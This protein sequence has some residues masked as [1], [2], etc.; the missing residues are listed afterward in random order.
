MYKVAFQYGGKK[1]VIEIESY[2]SVEVLKNKIKETTKVPLIQQR[3]EI[4]DKEKRIVLEN[5][6]TLNQF[7]NY[8]ENGSL[9]LFFKN[10]G[11]QI[12][13]RTLFFLEYLGPFLLWVFFFLINLSKLNGY[14]VL[15]TALVLLHYGKRLYESIYVHIFSNVSVPY[16][17]A[18]RN[19]VMYWFVFGTLVPIEIYY[20]RSMSL[21]PCLFP[22]RVSELFFTLIFLIS[23]YFNYQCHMVLRN[24]RFETVNG[25]VVETKKRLIPVGL[26]FD[27]VMC[28]N[29]TFEIIAWVS[30][31]FLSGS[32]F[33]AFFISFGGYVMYVWGV[34]KKKK[35]LE[36]P[37][38]TDKQ[39]DI[40][41]KRF[42]LIPDL[43]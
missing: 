33:S 15:I 6:N 25:T 29:Y 41:K 37:D 2:S 19:F 22:C 39:K 5:S 17:N 7:S 1:Q 40:V 23:E 30:F 10:L 27:S 11:R 20:L 9:E 3:L 12:E 31:V 21:G 26:F 36:S 4:R 18:W 32:F 8:V 24:L 35:L 42:I 34:G 28:P 16:T 43:L 38:F 13:Y 14:Y